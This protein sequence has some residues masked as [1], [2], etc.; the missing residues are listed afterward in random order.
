MKAASLY[1]ILALS[2]QAENSP[3]AALDMLTDP[4]AEGA[5]QLSIME[6]REKRHE[7]RKRA[8]DASS[9]DVNSQTGPASMQPNE[10]SGA[11]GEQLHLADA[12]A[13][14]DLDAPAQPLQDDIEVSCDE[15]LVRKC[16]C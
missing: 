13:Q 8:R 7:R 1:M 3:D 2:M 11:A 10:L 12:G 6:R 15:S 5:I 4:E 16:F 9:V 14:G